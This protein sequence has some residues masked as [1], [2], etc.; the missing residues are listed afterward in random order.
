MSEKIHLRP[1]LAQV[2]YRL[3]TAPNYQLAS[4]GNVAH[5]AGKF[6]EIF[7]LKAT[8]FN[9]NQ[10]ALS[11]QFLSFRYIFPFGAQ[12]IPLTHLPYLDVALGVDQVDLLFS[13]P[14]TVQLIRETSLRILEAVIAVSSPT[15]ADHYFEASLHAPGDQINI[16]QFFDNF[17]TIPTTFP[18]EKGFAFSLTL[19]N[20]ARAAMNLD[21]S[22]LIKGGV[23][24]FFTYTRSVNAKDVNS[25]AAIMD[26][27]VGVYRQFQSV[28][29]IEIEEPAEI[30][31]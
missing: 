15:M 30:P 28:A 5:L 21:T 22:I 3:G 18:I 12:G 26:S 13:N 9:F 11:T 7:N 19:E 8:S 1:G 2:R 16:R 20:G 24:I 31:T 14:P 25:I 29:K 4:P 27:A 6:A 17:V 23:F 10:N